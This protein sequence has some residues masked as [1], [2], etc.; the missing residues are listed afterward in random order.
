MRLFSG[1]L[2]LIVFYWIGVCPVAAADEIVMGVPTATVSIDP[3]EITVAPGASGSFEVRIDVGSTPLGAYDIVLNWTPGVFTIDNIRAGSSTQFGAPSTINPANATE[4]VRFND[5]QAVGL[6]QPT[7]SFTV[8]TVNFTAG[9]SGSTEIAVTPLELT[10]TNIELFS[11]SAVDGLL[12]I[13]GGTTPTPTPTETEGGT[14]TNT[15]DG[16][17]TAVFPEL[18]LDSSDFIGPE[19]LLQLLASGDLPTDLLRIV[20]DWNRPVGDN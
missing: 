19:D 1:L 15:P 7:G 2:G 20:V 8:A 14:P 6:D 12:T 5:F 9:Q 11:A 18:D 10:S 3:S 4:V 16:V 13:S 17:P